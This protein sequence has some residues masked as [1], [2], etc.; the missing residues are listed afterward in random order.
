MAA[1]YTDCSTFECILKFPKYKLKKK[2]KGGK[3]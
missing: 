3:K 1:H 2:K